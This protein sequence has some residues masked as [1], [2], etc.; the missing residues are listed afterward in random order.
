MVQARLERT[1]QSKELSLLEQPTYK[2][3]WYRPDYE[4]EEAEAFA[5]FLADKVEQA[6]QGYREP[7]TVRQLAAG[8]QGD[9]A[10]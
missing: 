4:A 2:R 5:L 10:F 6:A 3:R 7:F 8:L 1:A 9:A